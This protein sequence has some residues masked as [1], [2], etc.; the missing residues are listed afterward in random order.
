MEKELSLALSNSISDEATE[1][2]TDLLEIGLDSI[3]DDGLLKEVPILST[4]VSLYKIGHSIKERHQLKKLAAFVAALNKGII[5]EEKREYYRNAVKENA[6]QRDKELEY[7]LILIDRYIH[8]SKAELLAKLFLAYLD[9]S[10]SW[11]EFAK[12]AE[13]LDRLLPGDL[14]FLL[15]PFPRVIQQGKI[16]DS[17]FRVSS[18]GLIFQIE[19]NSL[20]VEDG[21]GGFSITHE[22]ME[23]LNKKES[24]YGR[25]EFGQVLSTVLQ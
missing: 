7:I 25:T 6:R 12:Y 18:L 5:D 19:N 23:R 20:L 16:E 22:S 4:A 24:V 3:L 21:R 15:G 1:I 2:A 17:V 10:I 11:I 14:E 13:V 8:S 9:K